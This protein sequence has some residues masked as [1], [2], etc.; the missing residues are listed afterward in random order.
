MVDNLLNL[1]DA[2]A[3][4]IKKHFARKTAHGI[5]KIDHTIV[6]EEDGSQH[7]L[8][9][10]VGK[11]KP[12]TLLERPVEWFLRPCDRCADALVADRPPGYVALPNHG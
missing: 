10:P 3:M 6:V 11:Y 7:L 5:S 2:L 8:C 1:E 12:G 4:E 9:N